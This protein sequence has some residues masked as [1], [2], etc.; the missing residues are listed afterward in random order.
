MMEIAW[1]TFRDDEKGSRRRAKLE[2]RSIRHVKKHAPEKYWDLLIPKFPLGF[3]RRIFDDFYLP[4]LQSSKVLLTQD[5]VVRVSGNTVYTASGAEYKADVVVM[6]TGFKTNQWLAPLEIIGRN[7]EKLSDHWE[8]M[9]GPNAY[10]T[11]AN[12]GFPNF[13]MLVG[14]NSLT[15][16]TSVIMTSENM[17]NYALKMIAPILKGE[18]SDVEVK[19]EAEAEYSQWIQAS[20][21]K[22]IWKNKEHAVWYIRKDGW[23]S[24][25]YPRSQLHFFYRATFPVYKDWIIRNTKV[26]IFRTKLKR[27]LAFLFIFSAGAL[28]VFFRNKGLTLRDVARAVLGSIGTVVEKAAIFMKLK[29]H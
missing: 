22:T 16:H 26:G 3:K 23:N 14:P 8:K 5:D 6:A 9:G 27:F 2:E 29:T 4:A 11:T 13:F 1:L 17:T 12:S 25:L 28:S 15:G 24:S 10:N 7:E 21:Q 19:R 20:L 18:V